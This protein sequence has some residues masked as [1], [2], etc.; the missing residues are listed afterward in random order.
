[1]KWLQGAFMCFG[2][3]SMSMNCCLLLQLYYLLNNRCP[4]CHWQTFNVLKMTLNWWA[5]WSDTQM[6]NNVC[7]RSTGEALDIYQIINITK[8]S[9]NKERW[10]LCGLG[11]RTHIRKE[12]MEAAG[13]VPDQW[14]VFVRPNVFSSSVW[15]PA[16]PRLPVNLQSEKVK[17]TPTIQPSHVGKHFNNRLKLHSKKTEKC[18]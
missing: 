13:Q 9:L 16:S 10:G 5:K 8:G 3:I 4:I 17:R 12:T 2:Q 15:A 11:L 1:M 18:C 7:K 6:L 14:D